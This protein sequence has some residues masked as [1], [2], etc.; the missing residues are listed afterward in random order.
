MTP[1]RDP[2]RSARS[3]RARWVIAWVASLLGAILVVTMVGGTGPAD[4]IVYSALY[5]GGHPALVELAKFLSLFGDPAV[6]VSSTLILALWLWGRGHRHSAL[7]LVAVTM[8]GRGINSVVKLDV[9]RPRPTLEHHLAIEHTNSFPSGHSAGSMVFFLT[10]ALIFAHRG[11]WRRAAV[12]LAV[13]VAMLVGVSRVML[14]VHWPSDVIGGWAFGALWVTAT[15][16]V[17]ED[18]VAR[19]RRS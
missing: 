8:I 12:G 13:V 7:T 18:V 19:D 14:G 3:P 17:S 1:T 16:R 2:K 4:R 15:L 10:V 5:A 6:L 11:R 9:H